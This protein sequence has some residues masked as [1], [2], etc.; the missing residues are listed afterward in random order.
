MKFIKTVLVRVI[1][2]LLFLIALMLGANNSD[3]A[4]L[5]FLD[6]RT[7]EAPVTVWMLLAFLFGVGLTLIYNFWA[8]T[9]LRLAARAARKNVDKVERDI[10]KLKAQSPAESAAM[11]AKADAG[12]SA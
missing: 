5:V 4:A 7:P 8:N 3:P 1:A 10:D 9:K 11:E 2:L 12:Q 6:W